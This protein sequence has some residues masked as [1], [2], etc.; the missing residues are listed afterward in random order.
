[1][2]SVEIS[3]G[4]TLHY[5][6]A[7]EGAPV[8]L[9]QGTGVIGNAWRPQADAL[10]GSHH[11]VWY[12]NRGIGRSAPLSGD[13]SVEQLA[14]DALAL[15]DAL[16][17]ES[18]HVGGHSLGGVVA[19]Q[20]ALDAPERVR[21]LMLLNTFHRGKDGVS[22]SPRV[23]WLGLRTRIG[24]RSMRRAAF[25]SMVLSK[26]TLEERGADELAEELAPFFG[27]DIADSPPIVMK[28]AMALGRHDA[29]ARLGELSGIPTLVM[30][31]THDTIAPVDSGKRLAAA[32][33]GARYVEVDGTH[34][35]PLMK[36]EVVNAILREHLE[37]VEA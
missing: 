32:I 25:L 11:V 9:I 12:D 14:G 1:M 36:P 33:E 27:R 10:A 6:S 18:A 2:P 30:S 24:T 15:M 22:F 3:T 7:G 5:E 23:I 34:A 21:S 13:T 37:G 19:Q 20:L 16:E 4:T 31:G 29:S 35:V 28:Q 8:L 17:I 26:E